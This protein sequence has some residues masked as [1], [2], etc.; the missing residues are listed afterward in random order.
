MIQDI[1]LSAAQRNDDSPTESSARILTLSVATGNAFLVLHHADVNGEPT[2]Q[3]CDFQIPARSL[4]LA[5][6][7]AVHDDHHDP[8][9]ID[10][11][12][13][14]ASV[15][16]PANSHQPWTPELDRELRDTWLACAPDAGAGAMIREIAQLMG[17][18]RNGIRSRLL[19][20]GCN[21]E[22]PGQAIPGPDD[23][24]VPRVGVDQQG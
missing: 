19:R 4:L 14:A 20:V 7:A 11:D 3:L 15:P 9:D 17:R 1:R 5:L 16:K 13:G 12:I 2:E 8:A 10:P 21:P 24:Q 23:Q 22:V 18:S 6:R